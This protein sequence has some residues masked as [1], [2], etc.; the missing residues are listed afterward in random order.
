[1]A[2]KKPATKTT[3]VKTAAKRKEA[4]AVDPQ[5]EIKQRLGR[6]MAFAGVMIAVL[7][8]ALAL[9]DHLSKAPEEEEVAVAPAPAP[10]EVAQPVKPVEPVAPPAEEAKAEEKPAEP[11]LSAAPVTKGQPAPELPPP[12]QVAA[13]PALPAASHAAQ[14]IRGATSGPV[15]SGRQPAQGRQ[16]A[17]ASVTPTPAAAAPAG[18]TP[19]AQPAPANVQPMPVRPQPLPPRLFSGYVVQAGV[20]SSTERAEELHAKL[21]LNGIPSNIESRVNLGPFKSKEEADAA[22]AKLRALGIDSVLVPPAGNRR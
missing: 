11:E 9:F 22:R 10:K 21:Q 1:M 5:D 12:P 7:L 14:P 20:F 6:R 19:A 17:V 3:G 15:N 13:K 2:E 18:S 8:A 16:G 4:P